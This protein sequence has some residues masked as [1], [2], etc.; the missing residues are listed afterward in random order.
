VEIGSI[1]SRSIGDPRYDTIRVGGTLS[2]VSP[3]N[4]PMPP[5]ATFADEPAIPAV[6]GGLKT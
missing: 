1:N 5:G 3:W 4:Q 2:A 6:G